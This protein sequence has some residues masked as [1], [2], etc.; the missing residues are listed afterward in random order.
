MKS[1]FPVLMEPLEI[2]FPIFKLKNRRLTG[3]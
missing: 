1:F 2:I 3:E